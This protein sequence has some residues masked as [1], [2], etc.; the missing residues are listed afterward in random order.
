MITNSVRKLRLNQP[1]KKQKTFH[2]LNEE[3]HFG[4]DISHLGTNKDY[5]IDLV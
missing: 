1:I 2:I 5:S 4:P 3:C